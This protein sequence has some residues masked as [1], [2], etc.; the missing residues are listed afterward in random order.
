MKKCRI[1]ECFKMLQELHYSIKM[2]NDTRELKVYFYALCIDLT[3]TTNIIGL[4]DFDTCLAIYNDMN[5]RKQ[6][7]EISLLYNMNFRLW[8]FQQGV[9]IDWNQGEFS[10]IEI[11]LL[12]HI[13][14]FMEHYICTK[15]YLVLTFE[16][17]RS[18]EFGDFDKFQKFW[19]LITKC[20]G[21]LRKL[22]VID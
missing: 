9:H 13:Q 15:L 7:S 18:R 20:Q 4:L 6:Y 17:R 10:K 2:N 22:N 12:N 8:S 14:S 19:K 16:L 5:L 1:E 21:L 3:L 11:F